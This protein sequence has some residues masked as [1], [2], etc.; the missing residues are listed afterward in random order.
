MGRT[1]PSHPF[2]QTEEGLATLERVLSS[3]AFHNPRIGYTQSH[4]CVRLTN[5][6]AAR[7]AAFVGPNTPVIF[8]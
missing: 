7:V 1:L 4:G 5:W 3:Y 8:K 2:Y 6:D